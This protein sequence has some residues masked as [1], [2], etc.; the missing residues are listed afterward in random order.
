MRP[1]GPEASGSR[2]GRLM[3]GLKQVVRQVE[4]LLPRRG[5][6][7]GA[8]ALVAGGRGRTPR[9]KREVEEGGSLGP[10][11][12]PRAVQASLIG[13]GQGVSREVWVRGRQVWA[14]D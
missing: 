14:R 13:D 10:E 6:W 12:A 1:A 11:G 9:G 2:H 7:L 8:E 3:A 5:R 4:G